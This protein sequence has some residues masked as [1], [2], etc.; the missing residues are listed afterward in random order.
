VSSGSV[1]DWRGPPGRLR[2]LDHTSDNL[3]SLL[4]NLGEV[5]NALKKM[6]YL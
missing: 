3:K 1:I 4:R 6:L 5:N 2:R